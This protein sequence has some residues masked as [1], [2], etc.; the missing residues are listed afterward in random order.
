[1][2]A[3]PQRNR[4]YAT[5]TDDHELATIDPV[6]LTVIARVRA[7]DYP[8]GLAYDAQDDRIFVSDEHGGNDIVIDARSNQ[9]LR[10]IDLGGEVGNTQYNEARHE[11]V[12]AAQGRD[13]LAII[14]PVSLHVV[15]RERTAGCSGPHGVLVR[16]DRN[17]AY[18]A[19]EANAH[20]VSVD[21]ATGAVSE[22]QTVGE[23]PDVLAYDPKLQRLYAASESGT[24]SVFDVIRAS[25]RMV[26]EGF[27]GPKAHSV[28][29]DPE[30]HI[31]YLPLEDLDGR[32]VLREMAPS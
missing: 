1:M 26:A 23:T 30:T 17:V 19:C 7:G 24:L 22:P 31:V 3:V 5:A 6:S 13:E 10:S 16:P 8:D 21:L 2:I 27:A 28:A 9:L 14:D 15:R 18:V 29:V 20:L 12:V 32:P 4:I 25:P 11:V